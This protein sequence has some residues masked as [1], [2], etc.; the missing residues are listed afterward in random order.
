MGEPVLTPL[1]W[2]RLFLIGAGRMEDVMVI[3]VV[4]DFEIRFGSRTNGDGMAIAL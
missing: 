1:E 4:D 3:N 2:F